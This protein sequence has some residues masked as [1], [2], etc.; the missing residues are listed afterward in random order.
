VS[1]Q[2]I[3]HRVPDVPVIFS[4]KIFSLPAALSWATAGVT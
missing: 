1:N 3:E 2:Q 4:R